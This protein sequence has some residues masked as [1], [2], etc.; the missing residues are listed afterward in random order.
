MKRLVAA[1]CW[2]LV[3][4]ATV[5]TSWGAD[6]NRL[7][8]LDQNDPFYVSRSFPKLVTPQ[9]IG[10]EGVEA[11]IVLAIDDLK[12]DKPGEHEKWETFLRPVLERLKQIDGRAPVSIMTT[13]IDPRHPRLQSW[14]KEGLSLEV[15]TYDHPCPL[16][17]GGDLAKAKATYDRCVEQMNAIPGNRAVAFRMPCC[18]SINSPSPRFYAEI[19]NRRTPSGSFLS[20]DSSVCNIITANDPQLPRELVLDH[21]AREIFRKYLPFKSFVTTVEDYSYP[22]VI[23]GLCWEFPCVVPSDWSAQKLRKP[24]NPETVAD[25]KRAIDATVIKQGVFTLIFHPHKWITSQQIVELVDHAVAK[26]GK[27]VKFLNFREAQERLNKNLLGGQ[28]LRAADGSDNGVRLVDLDADGYQDVVIGNA[29]LRQTRIWSPAD[30]SWTAGTFPVDLVAAAGGARFGVLDSSGFATVMVRN[31]KVSGAWRFDGRAWQ[32]DAKA[33]G[34]LEL[35]GMPVLASRAGRDEGVRL[36]D[37]DA[38]GICELLV[39]TDR[40]SAVFRYDSKQ[41]WQKTAATLPQPATIVDRQGRDAG[42]RFVDIDQDGYDDV[43]FS[44][45]SQFSANLFVP[46]EKS[47]SRQ[48]V[49]GKQGS[50]GAIPPITRQGTNNGA[51]FHDRTLFVQNEDTD[52]LA[53]LVDRMPLDNL[54]KGVLFPGPKSPQQSLAVTHV[55][56]GFQIELAAAEPLVEDPVAFAWGPD[57][58]LWVAEMGDYPRGLDGKG[59]HGGLIRCL[60]DVDGDG[61]YDK[62]AVFLDDLGFPTGVAPWRGGILVSCAGADLCRGHRWRRQGRQARSLVQQLRRG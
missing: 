44:N 15:H 47:W 10:E 41:G 25:F 52:K 54:L 37:I 49:A 34:A 21:N 32:A 1:C 30:S 36:R 55:R 58:K 3:S 40:Q 38:D 46:S 45:E 2:M 28:S 61:R 51:W 7:A 26:H 43:L 22:Y 48:L 29:R 42:L 59:K 16:L 17:Q 18:D 23:G 27:K 57:G 50:A 6:G 12:E 8:Y 35:D 4:L 56:P 9:W 53:D 13:R 14:L 62:S 20:I 31:E 33:A 39:G 24:D 19:F 5:A 11:V 60:E